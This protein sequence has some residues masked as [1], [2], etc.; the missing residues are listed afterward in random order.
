MPAAGGRRRPS[1]EFTLRQFKAMT[2]AMQQVADQYPG[3]AGEALRN[4]LEEFCRAW[5]R[6]RVEHGRSPRVQT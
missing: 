3:K 2:E 5:G 4:G 1:P 6:A